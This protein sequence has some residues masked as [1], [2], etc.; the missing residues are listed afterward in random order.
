MIFMGNY[1]H[2]YT[3]TALTIQDIKQLRSR[4]MFYIKWPDGSLVSA[5]VSSF[6][7]QTLNQ[8]SRTHPCR[9]GRAGKRGE[10]P[11][12]CL[13][14][15]WQ[16]PYGYPTLTTLLY[17]SCC[18]FHICMFH[19]TTAL[20]IQDIKQLRS[21]AM[22]YIKWPDGSLVSA[23]VSSFWNQTLNQQSRT[24][25]S[26]L[27]NETYPLAEAQDDSEELESLDDSPDLW[28]SLKHLAHSWASLG[29][30]STSL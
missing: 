19:T 28:F 2:L 29:R 21:R 18:Y 20:T 12:G 5:R 8:Q 30:V 14:Q 9:S 23:R 25:L 6:W 26:H 16:H 17:F 7:N 1:I 24:H 11:S 15:N 10:W 27:A 3:T 13:S 4:A 22:F